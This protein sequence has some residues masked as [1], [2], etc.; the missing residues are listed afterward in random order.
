MKASAVRFFIVASLAAVVLT[1]A[2]TTPALAELP[3]LA[4]EI[5][6]ATWHVLGPFKTGSREAGPDPLYYFDGKRLDTPPDFSMTYPS[7]Y[8]RGGRAEWIEVE[9]GEEGKI[10]FTL[11]NPPEEDWDDWNDEYGRAGV[12]WRGIAFTSITVEEECRAVVNAQRIG[13]FKINDRS[14]MGDPY[15]RGRWQTP[16]KLDKGVNNIF[17]GVGG[18]YGQDSLTFSIIPPPES[19]V[20]VVEKDIMTPDIRQYQPL[21]GWIGI[22]LVNYTEDWARN[23]RISLTPAPGFEQSSVVAEPIPPF[24]MLKVPLPIRTESQLLGPRFADEELTMTL[25]V[26]GDGFSD[27]YEVK[28]R[29]RNAE[30]PFRITFISEIDGSVQK[31]SVR[32]PVP[33][34]PDKDYALIFSTHGAGVD[35]D[36]QVSCYSPKDWAYV[37]AP[38]NRRPFGFDW[39]DWGRL[40]AL[41]VLALV[42]ERFNI[43]ENRIIMTGHSMGGHGAWHIGT[44]HADKFAAVCPIAGWASFMLYTPYSLRQSELFGPPEVKHILDMCNAP[45]KT[46]LLLPNLRNTPVLAMHGEMDRVVPT[47]QPRLLIGMLERMGYDARLLEI[48]EATHWWD[49]DKERPGTDAVDQKELIEWMQ[50]KT[51]DPW[52]NEV[53]YVGYDLA[54]VNSRYWVEVIAQ[55][56]LYE[57]TMV[58]ARYLNEAQDQADAIPAD[59]VNT[60][61][62]VPS[63]VDVDTQ[64]VSILVLHFP[65]SALGRTMKIEIDGTELEAEAAPEG[66][67]LYRLANGIWTAEPPAWNA[68]PKFTGVSGPMKRA[69]FSP[70]IIV[71]ASNGE[72][73]ECLET[74]TNIAARWWYRANGYAPV[75]NWSDLTDDDK[76]NFNL[77]IFGTADTMDAELMASFPIEF[78]EDEVSFFGKV[79]R[80]ENLAVKCVR[81]SPY[82][83]ERLVLLNIGADADALSACSALTCLYS[84]SA[85]PDFIVTDRTGVAVNGL[86][87]VKAMGFF[88]ASWLP[89]DNLMYLAE[90]V[91]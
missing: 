75:K 56:K 27:D 71:D 12:G 32:P 89:D 82:N 28:F 30:E 70:F 48:P 53:I 79:V 62:P 77:I 55:R 33:F 91:S 5:T 16:M 3:E 20:G 23:V 26:S 35:S 80:G 17:I 68:A 81:P 63:G 49:F 21:D 50:D 64:N 61:L 25:T 31:Y 24:G 78:G 83:G 4:D 7:M 59:A 88:D 65:E 6:P 45:D 86:A 67:R 87:G 19:P 22:P 52:P 54:N 76:R 13:G 74:V 40:D 37:V 66:I 44:T 85:L 14:Y 41:E 11:P 84:G 46:E 72:V 15:G 69:Y 42:I 73:R 58:K 34:D 90:G 2:M 29:V 47:T 36:G 10:D 51:R 8:A 18:Y 60:V 38:T 39:Q 9:T 57:R 43:D 1:V